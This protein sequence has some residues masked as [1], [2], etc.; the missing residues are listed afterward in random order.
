MVIKTL[1]VFITIMQTRTMT[2]TQDYAISNVE[3]K[4]MVQEE[5]FARKLSTGKSANIT[6][7]TL[8]RWGSFMIELTNKQKEEILS[9]QVVIVSDYEYELNE[10]SDGCSIDMYIEDEETL[11]EEEKK[12]IEETTENLDEDKLEE[13]GWYGVDQRYTIVGPVELELETD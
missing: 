13:E 1:H 12:E 8:F 9:K 11:S 2:R 6:V 5:F 4:S 7:T 10:M 3:S